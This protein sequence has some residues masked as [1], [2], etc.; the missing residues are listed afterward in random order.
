MSGIRGAAA[1]VLVLAIGLMFTPAP[2][3]SAQQ[4]TLTPGQAETLIAP[5]V[6]LIETPFAF[7]SGVVVGPRQIMMNAHVVRPHDQVRVTF[8][9]GDVRT[10]VVVKAWDLLA[11]MVILELKSDAP[12]APLPIVDH[13]SYPVGTEVYS[14]GYPGLPDGSHP[15]TVMN[16]KITGFRTWPALGIEY[17]E[18]NIAVMG[19]M[20]GG[21]L[22]TATGQLIAF[23]EWSLN[24]TSAVNPSAVDV[25]ARLQAEL[26]GQDV[27]HLGK[28]FPEAV[29]AIQNHQSFTLLDSLDEAFFVVPSI[30]T[31][32]A[33]IELQAPGAAWVGFVWDDGTVLDSAESEEAGMLTL[34]LE[35]PALGMPIYVVVAQATDEAGT[36]VISSTAALSLIADSDDR[37]VITKSQLVWGQADIPFDRDIFVV[38]LEKGQRLGVAVDSLLVDQFVA[39]EFN[40]GTMELLEWDDDS[41]G[42]VWGLNPLLQFTAPVTGDYLLVIGGL[43]DSSTGGYIA[44]ISI[45][46]AAGAVSPT[47]S[48]TLPTD[49]IA[50]AVWGGGQIDEVLAAG[51]LVGCEVS[52]FWVSESGAMIGYLAGA[53]AFVNAQVISLYPQQI[54]PQ[55]PMLVN[56]GA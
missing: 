19:G 8:S 4:R 32:T 17:V 12:V 13:S 46:A 11:D 23:N 9:N 31:G 3:A 24:G 14:I 1:A 28:R 37:Q 21:A 20:S 41:G 40:D 25:A 43:L 27:D 55:T 47:F 16:G 10:N 26:A 2:H 35:I 18:S 42:G 5:A 56:C 30:F 34:S 52:S 44:N 15:L 39:V 53:P 33:L 6:V 45:T 36:F 48:G 49:G 7:G 51:H 29:G 54:P 38:P 50:L 22:I